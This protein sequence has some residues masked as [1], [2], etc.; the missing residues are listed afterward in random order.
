MARLAGSGT[1]VETAAKALVVGQLANTLFKAGLA[2]VLGAAPF[3]RVVLLG[4]LALAAAYGAGLLLV[5]R[6]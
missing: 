4:L 2:A 5:G 6:I 3:R 1:P